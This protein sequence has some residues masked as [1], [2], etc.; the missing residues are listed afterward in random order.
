MARLVVTESELLEALVAAMP[1]TAPEDAMTARE[2]A[3]S[4]GMSKD[5]V[6]KCLRRFQAAGR[7]VV[8]QVRRH[9]LAGREQVLP[10]YTIR[11]EG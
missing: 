2:L 3:E 11:P 1:G 7:L 5:W 4:V 9:D 10:A 8:H 6:G